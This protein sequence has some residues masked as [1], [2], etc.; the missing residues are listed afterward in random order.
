VQSVL[1]C[2]LMQ[3]E[4]A[5]GQRE[6]IWGRTAQ[7]EPN[8]R[9]NIGKVLGN[10][11]DRKVLQHAN[12][13]AVKARMHPGA[14]FGLGGGLVGEGVTMGEP[15]FGAH[16]RCTTAAV[17]GRTRNMINTPSDTPLTL[18]A[19]SGRNRGRWEPT[20]IFVGARHP[21]A[22]HFGSYRP[23]RL[24]E[25]ADC[26]ANMSAG[27]TR[28]RPTR[29]R[30]RGRVRWFVFTARSTLD[31]YRSRGPGNGRAL[32]THPRHWVTRPDIGTITARFGGLEANK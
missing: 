4:L 29:P 26:R 30:L 14:G 16:R 7:I 11:S 8:H 19:W 17:I 27:T 10:V 3:P 15:R 2:Q 6:I 1:H 31:R 5:T 23:T 25:T 24:S 12:T 28:P 32:V 21:Y 13:L 22:Q 18:A 9:T 20:P